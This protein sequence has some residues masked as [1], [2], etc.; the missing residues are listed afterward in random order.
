MAAEHVFENEF[1][2][3]HFT[4]PKGL[5]YERINSGE[6]NS[7][8]LLVPRVIKD[9]LLLNYKNSYDT[10]IKYDFQGDE[11]AF[12]NAFCEE[13]SEFIFSKVN[14]AIALNPQKY[15]FDFRGNNFEMFKPFK[16]HLR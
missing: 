16:F 12:L 8:W 1:V 9:Y 6:F 4:N 13:L 10:I 7:T 5:D 15:S 11:K 14:V 3:E 2:I